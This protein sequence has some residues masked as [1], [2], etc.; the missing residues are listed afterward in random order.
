MRLA[1]A[2]LCLPAFGQTAVT[3][4]DTTHPGALT[5]QSTDSFTVVVTGAPNSPV[6]V[7]ATQNNLPAISGTLGTTD[8]AGSFTISG[9]WAIQY[10]GGWTEVWTVGGS[11]ATISFYVGP[12]TP[13]FVVGECYQVPSGLVQHAFTISRPPLPGTVAVYLNG[14]RMSTP[15]GD[16]IISGQIITFTRPDNPQSGDGVC[17]DYQW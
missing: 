6:S 11:S 7:V 13:S 12:P 14:L 2:L 16:Y 10:L 1:L 4:T 3:L 8:A 9:Q 5:Y 17:F 15:A